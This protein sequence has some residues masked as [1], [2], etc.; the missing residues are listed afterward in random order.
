MDFY[1]PLIIFNCFLIVSN[2]FLANLFNF[3]DYPNKERKF[4]EKKIPLTGGLIIILNLLFFYFFLNKTNFNDS[5]FI[6]NYNFYIFLTTYII[7]YLF[8]V[9]DDK[10]N[11][12]ANKKFLLLIFILLPII[13]LD[14]STQLN[15]I[16]LSFLG[17][18]Y[19]IGSFSIIWTLIC[20]LLLLN[21]INMFDGINLQVGLYALFIFLFFI[22][23][24][25]NKVFF[26]SLS[27]GII[28]FLI[29][30]FKSESF[31]GDGGSYLLSFLIGYFFIKMYNFEYILFADQ[32]ALFM[33]LPGLDLMRLFITRIIKKRHP[34]SAD[35]NHLH[36][37]LLKKFSYYEV[38]IIIQSI[39][40]IPIIINLIF[41]YTLI[42]L[43][44]VLI[45]YS[46]M[47]YKYI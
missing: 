3:Y 26:I 29:L 2:R 25:F 33:L 46:I 4:H 38:I 20:F 11:F 1:I 47:V 39:I 17:Q 43:I 34:F 15:E 13:I 23:N 37:L 5:P 35:R 24:D 28:F 12:S 6:N 32:V 22:L 14:K 9:F 19:D 45:I 41:G 21:A 27:I 30:N 44:S 36:H 7:L 16:R 8:G 31:L 40:F 42:C 18:E 10:F